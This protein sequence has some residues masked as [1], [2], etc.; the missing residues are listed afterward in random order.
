MPHVRLQARTQTYTGTF[1]DTNTHLALETA[2]LPITNTLIYSWAARSQDHQA[3]STPTCRDSATNWAQIYLSPPTEPWKGDNTPTCPTWPEHILQHK[4]KKPRTKYQ[5][6]SVQLWVN[7][8]IIQ[9]NKDLFCLCSFLIYYLTDSKKY[10]LY[11][12]QT[13]KQIQLKDSSAAINIIHLTLDMVNHN[14][15]A[16]H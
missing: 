5:H 13:L 4:R 9:I 11:N 14:L 2:A 1:A 6:K 12:E 3:T 7:T 8:S 16:I 10:F 15:N